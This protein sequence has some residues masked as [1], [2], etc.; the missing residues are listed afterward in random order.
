MPKRRITAISSLVIVVILVGAFIVWKTQW[1]QSAAPKVFP[2]AVVS[3]TEV[4]EEHWQPSLQ[5]VG[6][7]VATHGI[8]VSTEVNGTVSEIVFQSGQPVQQGDVLIR[9]DDA[10]DEAALEALRAESK[11]AQIQFR[12]S[13]DLLKKK[14]ISK[15]EYDEAEAKFEAARARA[16]QQQA[17]IKRKIIRAPF[18]GL[19]GIR[20]VDLGEYIKDGDPIVSLQALDPI[21]VDYTL[22]ER[23]LNKIKTGQTVELQ[24][25]AMPDQVFNGEISALNSAIDTGTRTLKIRATLNNSEGLLR[26]G[27]FASVNTITDAAQGVHTLPHTAISFNTYGNFVFVITKNEQG[28]TVKRTPIETGE[29]RQGRVAVTGLPPGTQVV[30][31]GLVKLRDAMAVKVDNQIELNDAEIRGE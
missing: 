2:P 20:Q 8:N 1:Q 5:S 14:V 22:S 6:S 30:R 3:A 17:I 29:S 25:D 15:S 12:R 9:L 10:V 28:M 27:M 31:T 21:Y 16:R 23:Y 18:S 11:L 4:I 19:V 7:L 26:P 24:L 13:Q